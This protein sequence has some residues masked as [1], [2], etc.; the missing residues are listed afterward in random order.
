[1]RLLLDT[2]AVVRFERWLI[3]PS[4]RRNYFRPDQWSF[5]Q[6]CN[7]W[8]LAIKVRTKKLDLLSPYDDFIRN[9]IVGNDFIVLPIEAKHTSLLTDMPFHHKDPFD[10][11]LIAQALVE[12]I[13]LISI[14]SIFDQYG[15]TR[16]W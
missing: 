14:D 10:R 16:I 12:G 15:V 3:E 9:G 2:H 6:P 8:E 4:S 1:M 5:R 13:S 7:F 11:I